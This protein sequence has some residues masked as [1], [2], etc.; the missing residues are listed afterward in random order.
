V[1]PDAGA[2]ATDRAP[3]LVD[4]RH[5]LRG[6]IGGHAVA[7]TLDALG[8]TLRGTYAY[9]PA[10]KD[11]DLAGAR[12]PGGAIA[13]TEKL[14]GET[15]GSFQLEATE[16]G[17]AGTW[18]SPDGSRTL[19]VR[20]GRVA[21]RSGTLTEQA[22][23]CLADPSC[24]AV[25]ASRLLVAADDAHDPGESCHLFLYGVGVARDVARARACLERE[26]TRLGVAQGCRGGDSGDVAQAQLAYLRIDGVGGPQDLAGARALFDKCFVDVTKSAV[27][28]HAA[29]KERDRATKAV[30]FCGEVGGT[31]MTANMC[32]ADA[33]RRASIKAF[34]LEKRIAARLDASARPL[35]AAARTAYDAYVDA[36][37]AFAYQVYVEGSLRNAIAMNREESLVGA[38]ANAMAHFDS[39]VAKD[40]TRDDVARAA[41]AVDAAVARVQ[42]QTPEE[43]Q[44]LAK[45]QEAWLAYRDAEVALYVAAFGGAQG[46]ERVRNAVLV[47]LGGR[48]VKECEPPAP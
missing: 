12:G 20:L 13:L 22:N 30:D 26:V 23:A 25:E 44:A 38:R 34:L 45:T 10:G 19:P 4:G 39:F 47:E 37:G 24:L 15:T 41:R 9:D 43:K 17:L 2:V 27:L 31:M 3:A 16:S 21:P 18:S 28:D 40:V 29:D 46:A 42:T 14:A 36:E 48:R 1:T 33:Q 7:M 8:P 35:L 11:L 5:A 6:T 32:A